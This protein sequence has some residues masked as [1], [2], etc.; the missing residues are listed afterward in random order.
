[1]NVAGSGAGGA[2]QWRRLQFNADAM[3]GPKMEMYHL[4]LE[5][6]DDPPDH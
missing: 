4:S 1:V 5:G 3:K 2:R 6:P